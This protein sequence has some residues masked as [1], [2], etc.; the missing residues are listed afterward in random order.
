MAAPMPRVPSVTSTRLPVNSVSEEPFI[1]VF[2]REFPSA[3]SPWRISPMGP[4]MVI[5]GHGR[6]TSPVCHDALSSTVL[7]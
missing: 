4:E 3:A 6:A 1:Y 5:V 2:P 7:A